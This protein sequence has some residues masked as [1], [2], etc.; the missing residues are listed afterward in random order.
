MVLIFVTSYNILKS[1]LRDYKIFIL[2]CEMFNGKLRKYSQDSSILAWLTG[3][4]YE[5][6]R[7]VTYKVKSRGG[8]PA[9]FFFLI[10]A[11]MVMAVLFFIR[12]GAASTDQIN[13]LTAYTVYQSTINR[14]SIE[15]PS[16][17][18]IGAGNE[19]AGVTTIASKTSQID[20]AGG[21]ID[22]RKYR[23][24][25]AP[26]VM[27][28]SKIDV[29]SFD[30]ANG[31]SALDFLMSRNRFGVTGEATKMTINGVD[32]IRV[33][34]DVAKV[35]SNHTVSNPYTSVFLTKGNKGYIIAGFA[36]ADTLNRILNSFKAW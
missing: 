36:P 28:F 11:M 14:F 33:D 3:E 26:P 19:E 18:Q 23:E 32:A 15:Y 4:M 25:D 7:M 1:L 2:A 13:G 22:P 6:I 27:N 30:V 29:M 21:L 9:L 5:G 34:V 17:W 12:V 8:F 24:T 20:Q 10:F 16:S 35:L 31:T